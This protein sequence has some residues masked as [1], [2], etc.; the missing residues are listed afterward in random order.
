MVNNHIS[1]LEFEAISR[2]ENIA[3]WWTKRIKKGG[4]VFRTRVI[5][6]SILQLTDS[7]AKK[8]VL[9]AG[10]GDGYLSRILSELGAQVIGVDA[11]YKMIE[12]ANEFEENHQSRIKY[13][14]RIGASG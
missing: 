4:D 12:Y 2:W 6:P 5:T 13:K 3:E 14:V 7:I 11:S 8:N 9:D 1:Q 10:C